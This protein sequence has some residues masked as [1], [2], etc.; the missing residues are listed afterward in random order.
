MSQMMPQGAPP[1]G[2]LAMLAAHGGAPGA[3]GPPP[4]DQD[5]DAAQDQAAGPG[6]EQEPIAILKQMIT[7]GQKYQ[8]VEPDAE[9]KAT[10]AKL[11]ATLHQYLA[12]DQSDAEAALG[13]GAATRVM[14]KLG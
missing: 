3:G 5:N 7:L 2:L 10:M 1:P 4:P 9:D 13:G 6:A 11:L 14:R 12:K 8:A